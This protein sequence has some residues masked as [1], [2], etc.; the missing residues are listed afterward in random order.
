MATAAAPRAHRPRSPKLG[1]PKGQFTAHRK[2]DKLRE[3]LEHHQAGLTLEELAR[4]LRVSQRSVRRYLKELEMTTE[5]ESLETTPGAAHIWRIKPSERAR[6]VALRRT[7]AYGLLALRRVLDVLRGTAL[8]DELDIAFDEVLKIAQRPTRAAAKGEVSGEHRLEERFYYVPASPRTLDKRAEDL[9]E[10]FTA[11]ANLRVT[12]IR[13]RAKGGK[14]RR[15]RFAFH[16]YALLIHD[17]SLVVVGRVVASGQLEALRVDGLAEV[18][19]SERERFEIPKDFDVEQWLQGAFGVGA[20]TADRAIV[21]FAADAAKEII[22]R[23]WHPQ[24]RIATATDGRVRLSVPLSNRE[25][26]V[27]WVLSFADGARVI[28]PLELAAEVKQR[29]DRGAARYL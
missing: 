7:Q 12:E 23:R 14:A 10:L 19:A 4:T 15:E 21:E 17:G 29:L 22:A 18:R 24:Q 5:L 16:P 3:L 2:L 28:E 13:T 20:P 26:L 6:T 27:R 11:V 9:D 8:F 25:Q 1:R